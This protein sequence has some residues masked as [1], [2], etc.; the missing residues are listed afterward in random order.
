MPFKKSRPA[1]SLPENFN[2]LVQP[3]VTPEPSALIRERRLGQTDLSVKPGAVGTSNATKRENLGLFNYAHL[4][5]PFP[6]NF[7]GSE[8]H[9][10]HPKHG[11]PTSYF[12]MRR[13]NDGYVS[14]SGMFKAAF[15]WATQAEEKAE[16]DYLKSLESTSREEVAGNIWVS[17]TTALDL[18][19][20]YGIVAWVEALLAPDDV[21]KGSENKSMT[22][23]PKF[24]FTANDRMSLPP[25]SSRGSTPARARGRPR[26]GSPSKSEKAASP[27]KQR[28]TKTS[29][30]EDAANTRA[31]A[32]L[33][34]A[35]G[36]SSTPAID[37]E[38]END[39]GS[40]RVELNESTQVNGDVKTTTTNV[41]V[42]LPGGMAA[43]IPP[44]EQTEEI[45]KEAKAVVEAARKLEGG[46]SKVSRKRKADE[47]DEDSD[48][49]ADGQLQ[50]A[51][52][53]RLAE[54]ELKKERVKNRALFGVAFTLAVGSVLPYF[55]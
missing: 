50:P 49:E 10:H 8:I 34:D 45:I 9:P 43:D 44:Q 28:V 35:L 37:E 47:L 32:S 36:K 40:V 11:P 6:D 31:S 42:N 53:A 20:D 46:S 24:I 14:A 4:K 1:R 41:K 7:K 29:K 38:E 3:N 26:A 54:Q 22:P 25:P 48:V 33:Q 21:F 27:R 39:E 15:P 16:K 55:I 51:K 19:E 13:S 17:E 18:A 23:P 30:A 2:P 52:K 5:V 12:L